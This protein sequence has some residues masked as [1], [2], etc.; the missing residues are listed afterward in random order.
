MKVSVIFFSLFLILSCSDNKSSE[1]TAKQSPP[2]LNNITVETYKNDSTVGGFGY[3]IMVD[4]R[5]MIRQP[6][7]PAV[8]GNRGFVSEADASKAAALVAYKLKNN[9]MP[10]SVTIEELDSIGIK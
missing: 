1:K 6:N 10:P 2:L 7:I 4:G 8:M 3:N 5:L 9:I